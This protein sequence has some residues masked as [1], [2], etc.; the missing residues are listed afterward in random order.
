MHSRNLLAAGIAALLIGCATTGV[1]HSEMKSSLADPKS[2]DGRFY[3]YRLASAFGAA[4]QP[5]IKLN[6]VP[7]GT[8]RPGGFFY[9]DRP[10]GSYEAHATTEVEGMVSFTPS[11]GRPSTFAPRRRLG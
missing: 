9:V 4:V 3:F 6:G 2:G 8:S 5:E 7:V 10:P 1:R 11:R